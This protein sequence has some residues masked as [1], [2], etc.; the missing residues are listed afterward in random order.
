MDQITVTPKPGR[1]VK[2]PDSETALPPEGITTDD[3]PYWRRRE[4]DGD[5]DI[6]AAQ[7]PRK[8]RK[9]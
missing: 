1:Q 6:T 3:L 4:R 8:T 7:A 5:V 9:E 2:M